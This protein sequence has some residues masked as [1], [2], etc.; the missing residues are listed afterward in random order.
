[1]DRNRGLDMARG[2]A[3]VTMMLINAFWRM[4]EII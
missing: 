1:M 3:I 2:F 4:V